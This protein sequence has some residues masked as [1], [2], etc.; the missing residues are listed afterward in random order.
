MSRA[1]E[2]LYITLVRLL[3]LYLL[4]SLFY[5]NFHKTFFV[6]IKSIFNYCFLKTKYEYLT[7]FGDMDKGTDFI[8]APQ[9]CW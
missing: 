1:R 8:P 3:C 2:P 9:Y 7:R 4:K 5:I 6:R